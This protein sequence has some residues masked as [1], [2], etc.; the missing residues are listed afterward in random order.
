MPQDKLHGMAG[1]KKNQSG[2][3]LDPGGHLYQEQVHAD[4]VYLGLAFLFF[5]FPVGHR[6]AG[7][8]TARVENHNCLNSNWPF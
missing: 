3:R 2:F 8:T 4:A 7:D 5:G 1:K 6:T